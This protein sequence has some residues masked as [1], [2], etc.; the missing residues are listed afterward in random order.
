ML[1]PLVFLKIVFSRSHMITAWTWETRPRLVDLEVCLHVRLPGHLDWAKGTKH[2]L[3]MLSKVFARPHQLGGLGFGQ[4]M[5]DSLS[6]TQRAKNLVTLLWNFGVP[7]RPRAMK[8]VASDEL[9]APQLQHRQL[10][11]LSIRSISVS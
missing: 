9:I 4:S 10:V 2:W 11:K 5:L 8:A 3:Y 7:S 1:V 6:V